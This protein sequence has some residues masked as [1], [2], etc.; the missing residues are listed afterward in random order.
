MTCAQMAQPTS[1]PGPWNVR[2]LQAHVQGTVL[3]S[4]DS[5]C[6]EARLTWDATTFDQHPALVALPGT[7]AEVAAI[8]RTIS[9]RYR[10]GVC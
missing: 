9:G 8:V 1:L 2:D 6:D 5:K 4:V 3:V 7:S 10:F